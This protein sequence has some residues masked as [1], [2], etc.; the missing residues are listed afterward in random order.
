MIFLSRRHNIHDIILKGSARRTNE[1]FQNVPLNDLFHLLFQ[2][3]ARGAKNWVITGS[4]SSNLGALENQFGRPKK[5]DKIFENCLKIR[6]PQENLR[7]APAVAY[8]LKFC[9]GIYRRN[10]VNHSQ[11]Y[12]SQEIITAILFQSCVQLI[13]RTS[14]ETVI[15]AV[16][17]F[18]EGIFPGESHVA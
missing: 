10:S 14:N 12:R 3:I 5:V 15:K 16:V 13:V 2:T 4:F 11:I 7:S 18:A 9:R 8:D 1:N 6:P 17:V